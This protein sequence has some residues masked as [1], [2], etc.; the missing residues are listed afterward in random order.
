MKFIDAIKLYMEGRII[1]RS[2]WPYSCHIG[3]HYWQF[4]GEIISHLDIISD[5]WEIWE[6]KSCGYLSGCK[7]CEILNKILSLIIEHHGLR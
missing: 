1:R 6:N 4:E 7:S 3:L 2:S 5:D